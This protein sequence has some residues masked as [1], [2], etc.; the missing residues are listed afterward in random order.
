MRFPK[1]KH[2]FSEDRYLSPELLQGLIDYIDKHERISNEYLTVF[3]VR[4]EKIMKFRKFPKHD[5][6]LYEQLVNRV[7]NYWRYP[8][9]LG[10]ES[11]AQFA[12]DMGRLLVIIQML[13]DKRR[14]EKKS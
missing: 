14:A 10:S 12:H 8:A 9:Q 1:L 4:T 7:F 2:R 3:T 6:W 5:E 13:E 11:N